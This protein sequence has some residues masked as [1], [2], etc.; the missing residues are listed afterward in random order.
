[1]AAFWSVGTKFACCEVNNVIVDT[2]ITDI[3]AKTEIPMN[4]VRPNKV[5]TVQART[6]LWTLVRT[7]RTADKISL[8]E[9]DA[10][11][12]LSV[13][14]VCLRRLSVASL[15]GSLLTRL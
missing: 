5:V 8:C 14:V 6:V 3:A 2:A 4:R 9:T 12:F 10:L 11:A 7:R 1:M 15:I 13:S